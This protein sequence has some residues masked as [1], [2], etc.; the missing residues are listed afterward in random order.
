MPT[1][2]RAAANLDPDHPNRAA[3]IIAALSPQ[4]SW[5][6]NL[7]LAARMYADGR[8]NGGALS[9]S[10]TRAT[11]IYHGAEPLNVLQGPKTRAFYRLI[12]DPDDP[13]T[14]CIDRHAID[15]AVGERLSVLDRESRYPLNRH[16][17][18]E[19]FATVYR[20][21]ARQL[22]VTPSV[23]QATTWTVQTDRW[24]DIRIG[25]LTHI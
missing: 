22:A 18:Y 8:L 16:N 9:R 12:A 23:V 24:R 21:A 5:P 1:R 11:A 15:V 19:R 2:T 6:R 13:D 3:G 25:G 7:G 10:V 20:A 14:V 17:W 4:T